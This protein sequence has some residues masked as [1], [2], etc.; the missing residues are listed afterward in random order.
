MRGGRS[1]VYTDIEVTQPLLK[2]GTVSSTDNIGL[3]VKDTSSSFF[4]LL[5][6]PFR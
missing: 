5:S 1:E 3:V 6:S 4:F 2:D